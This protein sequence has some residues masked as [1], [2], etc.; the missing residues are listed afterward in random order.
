MSQGA[1]GGVVF[2]VASP[3]GLALVVE[4]P[5]AGQAQV[6]AAVGIG[7]RAIGSG[8][9]PSVI[10][11]SSRGQP[12]VHPAPIAQA[13]AAVRT[14]ALVFPEVDGN[15]AGRTLRVVAGRRVGNQLDGCKLLGWQRAQVVG[16]LGARHGLALAVNKHQQPLLAAQG[17]VVAAIHGYAGC[18]REHVQRR[19]ASR[20]RRIFH[21]NDGAVGL[22]LEQRFL[23][24]H[25]Y[26]LKHR[27]GTGAQGYRGQ[28][29]SRSGELKRGAPIA[30]VADLR[31]RYQVAPPGR[32][33]Q[34]KG[35]LRIA[36]L[37]LHHGG[38]RRPVQGDG[39]KL[40]GCPGGV[41]HRAGN[42]SRAL[43]EGR[44]R[45]AHPPAK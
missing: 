43:T 18:P 6:R 32:S 5:M 3:G 4:H 12:A 10:K 19:V 17:Q 27:G 26:F 1:G 9:S 2:L 25:S 29:Q 34:R 40:N 37:R 21:V 44:Q 20:Q 45:A 24:Q 31:R 38:I 35:P 15:D 41:Q 11:G 30:H 39:R 22:V 23:A 14:L 7:V 28:H 33:P 13:N 8:F 36:E 42:G 16:Q